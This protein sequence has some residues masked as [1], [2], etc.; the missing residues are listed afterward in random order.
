MD[1]MSNQKITIQKIKN[2]IRRVIC[3]K[4]NIQTNHSV[5]A[6]VKNSWD[7]HE[8]DIQGTEIYEILSCKGCEELCFRLTTSSSDNFEYDRFG[9][10]YHPTNETIYP[11]RLMGR[12]P[13]KE[14]YSLPERVRV[15]YKET[16]AAISSRLNILGGVGIRALVESVCIEEDAKGSNLKLKIDDLVSKGALTLRNA[17]ILHKT[18]LLGNK[19]AH[20]VEASKDSELAV[21]FDILENLLETLYIIPK[22]AKGLNI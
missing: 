14:Q 8:A 20:G 10:I 17:E 18:R 16:H 22:K 13:V 3:S 9:E 21:A 6:F 1:N 4:C 19:S 7:Y 15:I 12:A 5:H 11:N 2:E